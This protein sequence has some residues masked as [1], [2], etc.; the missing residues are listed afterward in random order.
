MIEP[1]TND[2]GRIVVYDVITSFNNTRCLSGTG[3]IC[4]Q[5]APIGEI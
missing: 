3:S 1:T 2:V 5:R 4:T